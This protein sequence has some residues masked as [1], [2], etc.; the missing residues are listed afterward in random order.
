MRKLTV[1]LLCG[2]TLLLLLGLTAGPAAAGVSDWRPDFAGEVPCEKIQPILDELVAS[3]D[4]V[5]YEVIG[6]SAGGHDL[7][8]VI[9]ARPDV[10]AGMDDHLAFRQLMLDD[11]AAAQA[12]LAA[13][14]GD[15]KVPLFIDCSIH[16]NEPNGVDAGLIMLRRLASAGED[17]LG[18][19]R[20][21]DERIVLYSICQKPNE[22]RR[23]AHAR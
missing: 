17:D 7:Y 11:P 22:H 8:L 23:H 1:L 5:R 6:T 4:R 3:S 21:L 14:P 13:A 12:Q 9:V 19:Q 18:A 15:V 2:L 16:G 20:I 10:P